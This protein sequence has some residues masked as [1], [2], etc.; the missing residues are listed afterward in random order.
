MNRD[1]GGRAVKSVDTSCEIIE[2]LRT[3]GGSTVSEIANYLD[4]S[5]GSVHTHLA[6]LKGH[7]FVVQEGREYRL[8]PQFLA[9][10]EH[11]RNN[12][13][14]YRSAKGELET[15]AE[16]TG[17]GVH[18]II[19]HRGRV[20]ALYEV[21]GEDAVGEEYHAQKREEPLDHLHCTAAGKAI[22]SRLPR[23]RVE[24]ILDRHGMVE[25]SPNTITEADALFEQLDR[26]RERG[27]AVADEE[28]TIGLRAVG[29]PIMRTD[30]RVEGAISV[31]GPASRLKGDRFHETLPERIMN[32]VN[33]IEVDLNTAGGI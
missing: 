19:E 3:T 28:Q 23:E 8:G 32:A 22:L 9:L 29:A 12:S 4:L 31:S 16:R 27:F 15:L 10:G 17:E 14:L 26:T 24:E 20:L 2:Y 5:A 7:G 13:A 6:T 21:F 25:R 1:D 18:L 33:A 30:G 11:F